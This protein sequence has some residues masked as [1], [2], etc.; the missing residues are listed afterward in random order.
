MIRQ[1]KRINFSA[2]DEES[3]ATYHLIARDDSEVDPAPDGCSVSIQTAT[4]QN[5]RTI[6]KGKYQ[7]EGVFGPVELTSDDP[8]AP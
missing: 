1:I 4:G 5:V 6:A 3:G 8:N 2:T 7:I